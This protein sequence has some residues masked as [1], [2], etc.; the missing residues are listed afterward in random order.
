MHARQIWNML[1]DV[2]GKDDVDGGIGQGDRA[3]VV[4][5]DGKRAVGGVVGFRNFDC[6]DVESAARQLQSLLAGSRADLEDPGPP[7]EM[8]RYPI[9][10]GAS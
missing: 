6:S 4:V 9:D 10:F 2:R 7:R 1:Q 8:G 3:T 5:D